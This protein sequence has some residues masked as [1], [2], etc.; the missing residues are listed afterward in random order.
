M[1]NR[2]FFLVIG[3]LFFV[4]GTALKLT[5]KLEKYERQSDGTIKAQVVENNGYAI[6]TAL[7]LIG[8]GMTFGSSICSIY[9][10]DKKIE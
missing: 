4:V 5:T 3:I 2:R 6:F 7:Q 8:A 10:K 1:F 9:R